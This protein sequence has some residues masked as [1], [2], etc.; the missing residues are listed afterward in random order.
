MPT[1]IMALLILAALGLLAS[2]F[3]SG[4]RHNDPASSVASFHRALSAM[5]NTTPPVG[6]AL[7]RTA[8]RDAIVDADHDAASRT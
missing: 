3:V 8:E 4:R 5:Q 1:V 6:S 2:Q 7:D